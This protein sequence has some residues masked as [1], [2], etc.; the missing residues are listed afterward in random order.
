MEAENEVPRWD[1]I[2]TP[3]TIAAAGDLA[4]VDGSTIAFILE[5][6][7]ELQESMSYQMTWIEGIRVAYVKTGWL[8]SEEKEEEIGKQFELAA[9]GFWRDLHEEGFDLPNMGEFNM[10]FSDCLVD[11]LKFI[12]ESL[13]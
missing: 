3:E 12:G 6:A 4:E 10:V 7:P 8:W 1:L 2:T 9:S 13:Q 5:R 11:A